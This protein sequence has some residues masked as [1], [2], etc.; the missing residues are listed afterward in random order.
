MMWGIPSFLVGCFALWMA[1]AALHDY[2]TAARTKRPDALQLLV[3][4]A[5]FLVAAAISFK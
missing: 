2:A 3:V 4:L 1:F 5:L